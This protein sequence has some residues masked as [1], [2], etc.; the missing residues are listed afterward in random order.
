MLE[1]LLLDN[2]YRHVL[3]RDLLAPLA[4][5]YRVIWAGCENSVVL[6]EQQRLANEFATACGE[7]VT[8][9]QRIVSGQ[10]EVPSMSLLTLAKQALQH[11]S[12]RQNEDVQVWAERLAREVGNA[13]D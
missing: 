7:A 3:T 6:G 1:F 5:F 9:A 10:L 2:P 4:P 11:C 8:F 13:T 12:A